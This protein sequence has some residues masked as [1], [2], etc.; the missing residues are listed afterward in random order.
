MIE[1][2]AA[3]NPY[4]VSWNISRNGREGFSVSWNIPGMIAKSSVWTGIFPKCSR[5]VQCELEYLWN[6]CEGFSV[7][8][9]I[10]R[11][12]AKGSV[13][14]GIFLEWSR[15]VQCKLE[16]SRNVREGFSM[17]WNISGMVARGSEWAGIFPE[18]SRKVKCVIPG[19]KTSFNLSSSRFQRKALKQ[20]S[21]LP[22]QLWW[23]ISHKIQYN[24]Q[25]LPSERHRCSL[26]TIDISLTGIMHNSIS[27][28]A[29]LYSAGAQHRNLHW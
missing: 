8:W 21:M 3:G 22:Q 29:Y 25:C 17:S 19:L 13:W 10:S 4:I 24:T 23:N 18:W 15:G 27:F 11:M 12:F 7:S 6:G 1:W 26:Q 28:G 16:Y 2:L 5:R 20:N 14:A 9:D